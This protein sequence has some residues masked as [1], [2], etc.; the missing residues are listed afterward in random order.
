MNAAVCAWCHR[1]ARDAIELL[2][3]PYCHAG[4]HPT[5]YD[6]ACSLA[7]ARL[8][9][10]AHAEKA[11]SRPSITTDPVAGE[12]SDSF[13]KIP[14]SSPAAVP[15]DRPNAIAR[16]CVE[17]RRWTDHVGPHH[18]YTAAQVGMLAD[19]AT[20]AL[21]LAMSAFTRAT[22]VLFQASGLPDEDR[23]H[24]DPDLIEET[25]LGLRA[26]LD[27]ARAEVATLR[28]RYDTLDEHA[29]GAGGLAD[30]AVD[31][32][33]EAAA[34]RGKVAAL[35]AWADELAATDPTAVGIIA[36]SERRR[37]ADLLRERLAGAGDLTDLGNADG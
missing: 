12:E 35:G 21:R 19:D 29:H 32:Q 7:A 2:G 23:F 25:V 28:G 27:A 9:L 4:D 30:L 16:Y 10:A 18:P 26:A 31:L 37:F 3:E 14:S 11:A 17:C 1:L 5:C 13:S 20:G 24:S 36:A 33:D 34:L 8:S 6:L 22:D 15:A